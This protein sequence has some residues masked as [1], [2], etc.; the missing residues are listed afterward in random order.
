MGNAIFLPE[1]IDAHTARALI[2]N[3]KAYRRALARAPW[4]VSV[5][6]S[7]RTITDNQAREIWERETFDGAARAALATMRAGP[8]ETDDVQ[9]AKDPQCAILALEVKLSKAVAELKALR[10]IRCQA[11]ELPVLRGKLQKVSEDC[12]RLRDL[13]VRLERQLR[14][15]KIEN[16]NLRR[17]IA[18]RNEADEHKVGD[19]DHHFR[20]RSHQATPLEP[21]DHSRTQLASVV[22]EV[23][24]RSDTDTGQGE[25]KLASLLVQYEQQGG[26]LSAAFGALVASADGKLLPAAEIHRRLIDLSPAE[27]QDVR[28]DD[29]TV[30]LKCLCK[31]R[32]PTFSE[33]ESFIA[34]KRK[35]VEDHPELMASS[36][37]HNNA[38][39]SLVEEK[40]AHLLVTYE[41]GGGD[42]SKAFTHW[43][44]SSDG[45]VSVDRIYDGLLKLDHNF[46]SVKLDDLKAILTRVNK[47][48]KGYFSLPDFESFVASCRTHRTEN[49]QKLSPF[50]SHRTSET[51]KSPL[52]QA[53]KKIAEII[54]AYE[55]S[56]GNLASAFEHSDYPRHK[57]MSAADIHSGLIKLANSDQD[58]HLNDVKELINRFDDS[59][60]A[61]LSWLE[62]ESFTIMCRDHIQDSSLRRSAREND[63]ACG[64]EL[65]LK[66]EK[67]AKAFIKFEDCGGKFADAFA[68]WDSSNNGAVSA[69]EIH[70]ALLELGHDFDD[71]SQGDIAAVFN[72]LETA[73]GGRV[74]LIKFES[75]IA[76]CCEQLRRQRAQYGQGPSLEAE[77]KTDTSYT[78]TAGPSEK[79]RK[80]VESV[81]AYEDGGGDLAKAFKKWAGSSDGALSAPEIHQSLLQLSRDFEGISLADVNALLESYG[82]IQDGRLSL[83]DF[84][85]F[86]ATCHKQNERSD[87]KK[88]S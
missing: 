19:N 20:V 9:P 31:R 79:C 61:R 29:I 49:R 11:R 78:D 25:N 21:H 26:D 27:F 14:D 58:I 47:T 41:D 48:K 37:H 10:P 17:Q 73:E 68:N 50:S 39:L 57:L 3:D 86:V 71:I 59:H 62:F 8:P 55:D 18:K 45:A 16:A 5:W 82:K 76:T 70:E 6:R 54:V 75:L 87:E 22:S 52:S 42:L 84:E 65:G 1:R 51:V 74:S 67:I 36:R 80:L 88:T 35:G 85:S 40:V 72:S 46:E 33:F 28:Q 60:D 44:V 7:G 43:D 13:V 63:E 81:V 30:F 12:E 2:G 32:N 64:D 15:E 77:S 56:G 66:E 38:S 4:V 69:S 34:T 23:S 83:L 24:P 53:E